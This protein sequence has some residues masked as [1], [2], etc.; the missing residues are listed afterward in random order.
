MIEE[1]L[2]TIL[3]RLDEIEAKITSNGATPA[4]EPEVDDLGGDEAPAPIT[5]KDVI[6]AVKAAAA[7]NREKTI[8]VLEKFKAKKATDVPE[9]DFAKAIAALEKVK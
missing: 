6:E 3:T 5:Q 9:A 2:A 1:T 7:R 4:A 8:A